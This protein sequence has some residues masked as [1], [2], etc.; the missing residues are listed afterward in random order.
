MIKIGD[1]VVPSA[2]A[3]DVYDVKHM[4]VNWPC[5]VVNVFNDGNKTVA[6]F[7]CN[8]TYSKYGAMKLRSWDVRSLEVADNRQKIHVTEIIGATQEGANSPKA[9]DGGGVVYEFVNGKW[10]RW[11]RETLAL[12]ESLKV[13]HAEPR[14]VYSQP[15]M[16]IRVEV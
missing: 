10:R 13:G 11:G 16:F 9:R 3:Y 5:K 6:Q 14:A 7:L 2:R 8:D 4:G 12:W 15:G 1:M